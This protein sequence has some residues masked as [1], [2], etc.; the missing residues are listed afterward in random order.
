MG[1]YDRFHD[2]GCLEKLEF[3]LIAH[4]ALPLQQDLN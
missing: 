4:L 3:A 1:L 2:L